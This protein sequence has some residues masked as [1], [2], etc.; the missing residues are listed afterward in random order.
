MS[1]P[2]VVEALVEALPDDFATTVGIQGRK[3]RCIEAVRIVT[4][5]LPRMGVP[6]RPLACDVRAA[7][8]LALDLLA[9]RVPPARWP[10]QARIVEVECDAEVSGASFQEPNRRKGFGGHLVV[11]GDDWFLDVTAPQ[12]HRP[13]R[14]IHVPGAL[15]G[16]YDPADDGVEHS[17][18]EGGLIRWLWRPEVARWRRTP[19]W[20]QD[21]PHHSAETLSA[22]IRRR[23][24]GV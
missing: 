3:G 18:D 20:R 1:L 19:A 7:G 24:E 13:D 11:V 23:L 6:C 9:R 21:I 5:I 10:D 2:L 12:F 8:S 15:S 14:G 17:L 4:A 22:A 16:P